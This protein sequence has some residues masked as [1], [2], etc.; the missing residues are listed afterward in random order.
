M[1]CLALCGLKWPSAPGDCSSLWRGPPWLIVMRTSLGHISLQAPQA[2]PAATAPVW[3]EGKRGK[4]EP[5]P[6]TG[7]GGNAPS[8]GLTAH[9]SLL[10]AERRGSPPPPCTSLQQTLTVQSSYI[11]SRERLWENRTSSV[12]GAQA[13]SL[14]Q[15]HRPH[16]GLTQRDGIPFEA[17]HPH[18]R[19]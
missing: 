11:N 13:G 1:V 17:K 15:A 3:E 16:R 5:A 9:G 14:G 12:Q 8:S 6:G 18:A 4:E 19:Y 2:G 10:T 7:A